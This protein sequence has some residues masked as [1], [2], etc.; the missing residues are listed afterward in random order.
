MSTNNYLLCKDIVESW[1]E[2]EVTLPLCV[3][4]SELLCSLFWK[5]VRLHVHVSACESLPVL[6]ASIFNMVAGSQFVILQLNSKTKICF[7]KHLRREIGNAV[8]EY[9]SIFDQHCLVWQFVTWA[10]CSDAFF[11]CPTLLSKQHICFGLRCCCS[12]A[13]SSGAECCILHL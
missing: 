7:W 8:T 5:P 1:A 6:P 2:K 13:P 3:L 4:L 12:S 9:W 11:F 10:V